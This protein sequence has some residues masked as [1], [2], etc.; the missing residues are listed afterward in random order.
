MGTHGVFAAQGGWGV[1]RRGRLYVC[2]SVFVM[3]MRTEVKMMSKGFAF[4]I[5]DNFR[6]KRSLVG[7]TPMRDS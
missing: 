2:K 3:R 4:I 7:K 1:R 5:Y 6:K